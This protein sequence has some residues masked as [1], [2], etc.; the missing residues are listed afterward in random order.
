[1]ILHF[2]MPEMNGAEFARQTRAKRPNLPTPFVTGFIDRMALAGIDDAYI[3]RKLF[4]PDELS[5]KVRVALMVGNPAKIAGLAPKT[6][7][8]YGLRL[9]A[10]GHPGGSVGFADRKLRPRPR[11]GSPRTRDRSL[12][13]RDPGTNSL[14]RD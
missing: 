1:M 8:G 2:A 13:A 3:V 4:V 12:I 7:C 9:G 14:S 6:N 11:R 10:V 5:R